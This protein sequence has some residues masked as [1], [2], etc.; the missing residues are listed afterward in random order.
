L[1]IG[2]SIV[3]IWQ[4]EP[5]ATA[6][7]WLRIS[8]RFPDRFLLGFGVGH[9][10]QNRHFAKPQAALN[11]YLD[12]LDLHGVPA[13]GRVLAALGPKT[14]ELARQRAGGVV[15]YL[16]TPEHTHLARST[17]GPELRVA[18]EHKVVLDDQVDRARS[19][20]RPRIKHPYLGLVNYTNN[21]RRLGFTDDDLA[22][23]GS[24]KLIDELVLHGDAETV[25]RGLHKH[26]E[27]GADHVQIQ[28][29]GSRHQPHPEVPD[30]YLQVYE[31]DVF[32]TYRALA[33]AL[34][35]APA[36]R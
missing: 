15:P 5:K 14:L 9:R 19:L 13:A 22:G 31:E 29:I 11:R 1:T 35:L 28:V 4:G 20:A 30:V 17:L 32:D 25:A 33:A 8:E 18:P 36:V 16:V 21:L 23:N 6:D 26:I 3:N 10:E 2:T 12:V 7:A 27:A 34:G 24:D